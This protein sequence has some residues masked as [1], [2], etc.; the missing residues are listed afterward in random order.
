VEPSVLLYRAM[1]PIEG[2]LLEAM[3]DESGVPAM[4][5]GGGWSAAFGDLPADSLLVDIRI[6]EADHAKGIELVHQYFRTHPGEH[7]EGGPET[8]ACEKC[9]EPVLKTFTTCWK[10]GTDQPA[11]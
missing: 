9:G 4:I 3:L 11:E 7:G 10:C 2:A 8:R 1:D 5:V 6:N